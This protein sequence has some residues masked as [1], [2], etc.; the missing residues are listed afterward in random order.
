N[1]YY[2]ELNKINAILE[3][4]K[5]LKKSQVAPM[6][7]KT[8]EIMQ[9]LN[10]YSN[11]RSGLNK[12]DIIKCLYKERDISIDDKTLDKILNIDLKE[13]INIRE[14]SYKSLNSGRI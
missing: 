5:E 6:S 2:R 7:K 3:S 11:I 14:D 8:I 13:F 4:K 12:K 1:K 9:I 10:K